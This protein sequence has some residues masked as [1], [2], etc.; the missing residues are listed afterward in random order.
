[1]KTMLTKKPATSVG[2][3]SALGTGFLAS[4]C[5]IGPLLLAVFGV[6]S[7]GFWLIFE[8]YRPF[9]M[10]LTFLFMGLSFVMAYRKPR[11]TNC[12]ESV[13]HDQGAQRSLRVWLWVATALALVMVF[14]PN[15]LALLVR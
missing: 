14:F 11:R 4:A 10:A 2:L 6:G 8:P 7:A 1:M 12:T 13:C 3:V 5:C 9:L 15:I